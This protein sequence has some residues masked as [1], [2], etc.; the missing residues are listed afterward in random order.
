MEE[1]DATCG[2]ECKRRGRRKR[3]IRPLRNTRGRIYR[4]FVP[5]IIGWLDRGLRKICN[6][7]MWLQGGLG[8][9][10]GCGNVGFPPRFR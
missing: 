8:G 9:V 7:G 4:V 1:V 5:T 2:I 10:G 6:V 3:V